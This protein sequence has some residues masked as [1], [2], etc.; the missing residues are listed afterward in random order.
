MMAIEDVLSIPFLEKNE[1]RHFARKKI[2]K[3]KKRSKRVFHMTFP[4]PVE[5]HTLAC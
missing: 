3:L 5:K 4:Q 1:F 2:K